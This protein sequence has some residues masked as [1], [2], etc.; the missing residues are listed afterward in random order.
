MF[1]ACMTA[2]SA[3]GVIACVSLSLFFIFREVY[4]KERLDV[5]RQCLGQM[6]P[7]RPSTPPPKRRSTALPPFLFGE[8]AGAA[9]GL[10]PASHRDGR[11]RGALLG[12]D[13]RGRSGGRSVLRRHCLLASRRGEDIQ[14]DSCGTDRTMSLSRDLSFD[15][16]CRPLGG[17]WVGIAPAKAACEL[18]VAEANHEVETFADAA[19]QAPHAPVA[20]LDMSCQA[21]YYPHRSVCTAQYAN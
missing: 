15:I 13:A 10:P 1:K 5:E 20:Q 21:R 11:R 9:Q 17:Q 8:D 3:N 2:W 14:K 16:F 12:R 7:E 19:T 4:A 6:I 18:R